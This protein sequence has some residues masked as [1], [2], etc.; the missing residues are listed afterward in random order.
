MSMLEDSV[1]VNMTPILSQG[2]SCMYLSPLGE[3]LLFMTLYARLTAVFSPKSSS[4]PALWTLS[5]K[6][7]PFPSVLLLE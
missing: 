6:D 1:M 7:V 4:E 2:A 5:P 3:A